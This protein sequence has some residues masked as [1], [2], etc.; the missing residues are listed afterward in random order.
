MA[1]RRAQPGVVRDAIVE[2]LQNQGGTATVSQ[3]CVG[4]REALQQPI[5]DS[6]VRSYLRLNA[7]TTFLRV[8]R[9][10]YRLNGRFSILPKTYYREDSGNGIQDTGRENVVQKPTLFE[11]ARPDLIFQFGRA[12]L[13]Q[14]DCLEWLLQCDECSIHAVVTDPPYGFVEYSHAEQS[15]LRRGVGGVWRIPPSF[16]GCKRSP[17]PR[18]TTLTSAHLSQ[19]AEFFRDWGRSLR[20]ALVPG[21]HVFVASNPLVSYAVAKA[22]V[23]AGLERR[24]EIIRL[25]MTLRGGDRPKNAHEEFPDVTVMPRSMWEPW[26]L[27]RKP[28]DGRVQDNLR[29]WKTGALRRVSS[30]QPFRD[31]IESSPTRKGEREIAPHPSLKPQAFL[32]KIVRAALPLGEGVVLDPFAGTGSTLAACEHIGYESIGIEVDQ[33]YAKIAKKAIPRLAVYQGGS[34]R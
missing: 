16:D 8:G 7:P 27:F 26:L 31:V 23:D 6:S 9:G 13:F 1:T 19:L 18:F 24:G 28:L 32:R 10:R 25:V 20:R 11:P 34:N 3:I 33:H 12:R 4:V 29:R 15:K 21:A 2:Y 22:L 14:N 17:L 30:D 5:P